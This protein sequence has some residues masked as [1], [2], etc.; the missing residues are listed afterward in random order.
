MLLGI[1]VVDILDRIK[2]VDRKPPLLF[3]F[4]VFST[5]NKNVLYI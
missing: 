4:K 1:A 2:N 3:F 5:K